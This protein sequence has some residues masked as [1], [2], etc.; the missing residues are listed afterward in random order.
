MI[1]F[2][3]KLGSCLDAKGKGNEPGP[4]HYQSVI[5]KGSI[6]GGK[7]GYKE[8]KKSEYANIGPGSYEILSD[9]DRS[10]LKSKS[11]SL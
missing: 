11:R 10:V 5:I 3:K 2:A 7:F 8:P 9:I 6:S 4:G 1:S